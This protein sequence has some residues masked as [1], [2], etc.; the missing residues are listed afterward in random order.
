M[1]NNSHDT[2]HRGRP[3]SLFWEHSPFSE[4]KYWAV[5]SGF[6]AQ[7]KGLTFNLI[8]AEQSF[9]PCVY[10]S[11]EEVTRNMEEPGFVNLVEPQHRQ[12]LRSALEELQE[13]FFWLRLWDSGLKVQT[14]VLTKVQR[15]WF[16][17]G[18]ELREW[19]DSPKIRAWEGI[20]VCACVGVD[21]AEKD[22][23]AH[24]QEVLSEQDMGRSRGTP[25]A[26]SY[27][28]PLYSEDWR[29]QLRQGDCPN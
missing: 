28:C 21:K 16:D 25:T 14:C 22:T 12:L 15:P 17:S 3:R 5:F 6:V 8:G 20:R 19:L 13:M 27:H 9:T 10:F 7:W 2:D 4:K 23:E 26:S 1:K 24:Q 29:F 11:V 18:G